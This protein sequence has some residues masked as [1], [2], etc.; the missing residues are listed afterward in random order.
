VN[1][2]R[3]LFFVSIFLLF[4]LVVLSGISV[5]LNWNTITEYFSRAEKPVEKIQIVSEENVVIDAVKN[6]S[7]SVVTIGIVQTKSTGDMFLIDPFNFLQPFQKKQSGT[8]QTV[9]QD[10]GSGFVVSSDGLIVTNKHVVGDVEGKYRVITKDDKAYDVTKIYRDPSNDL[11]ILKVDAVLTPIVMGDSSTIEV[12]QT[13]IA[14]GTALG[15]FRNTVT[16]GVISGVG[17]GITAGGAFEGSAERIDNVIQTDAAINLGNSGGPL[18]N[19]K[20]QA[21]GINTAVSSDGQNIGFALPINVVKVVLDTFNKTGQF[22]R[23][24][25]GVSYKVITKDVAMLNNTLEGVYLTYVAKGSPAFT[26]GLSV[27]DILTKIDDTQLTGTNTDLGKIIGNKRVGDTV[28]IDVWQ[29]G[30]TK[31]TIVLL[32]VQQ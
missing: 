6:V 19:S 9:E 13:A 21:I 10:I 12:G 1:T 27:G 30:K 24:F 2:H 32:G 29:N 15:E 7:P 26:S 23:P 17:R 25:L 31:T 8:V 14:I 3:I 4:A 28:K 22:N 16:T 18:L 20:G 5:F 11:A